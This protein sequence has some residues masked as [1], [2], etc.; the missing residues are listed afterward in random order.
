MRTLSLL[1]NLVPYHVARWGAVAAMP[2]MEVHILQVRDKDDFKILE[3]KADTFPFHVHTL[4]ISGKKTPPALLLKAAGDA[5]ERLSPDVVVISGYSFPVSL[6]MLVAASRR[7]IPVVVCSESNRD[8]ATRR[9]LTETLK[10]R[11]VRLCVAGIAG[12][13]PQKS[14]LCELGLP[15]DHVFTG[16]NAVDNRH[17]AEK[18][19]EFRNAEFGMRNVGKSSPHTSNCQLPTANSP[20]FLAVARFTPKKNLAGLINAYAAFIENKDPSAPD[21]VILG[22]GPLRGELEKQISELNLPG[23]VH[24]PGAV[25]Y[26]LLPAYYGQALAFIHASTTEQWGLVVNE[27]MASGLPVIISNR[28]GC[29]S[30]LVQEGVNGFTFDPANIDQ[31]AEL[32]NRISDSEFPISNFGDASRRIVSG[33]SPALFA[34]NLTKAAQVAMNVGPAAVSF[35]DT[36]LLRLLMRREEKA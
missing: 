35:F 21:L 15:A 6:A 7:G 17:F 19:A 11:V 22:D 14:Y 9:W 29:A 27:A 8:D 2:G 34:E 1:I 32:M 30:D 3:A 33:W 12:G 25:P 28:C 16:Y 5:L 18:A 23:R 10:R 26:D 24:L 36:L 31:L 13:A 4:G 20:F